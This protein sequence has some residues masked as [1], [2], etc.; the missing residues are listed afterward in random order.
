MPLAFLSPKIVKAIVERL[1]GRV[2]VASR[3]GETVFELAGL[4]RATRA[5]NR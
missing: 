3:P 5:T 1:G 4:P 2:S